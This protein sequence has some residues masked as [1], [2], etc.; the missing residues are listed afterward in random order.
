MQEPFNS[1]N[2]N[3]YGY[4]INNPLK[5][6][7]INGESFGQW[8]SRN[9]KSIGKQ[10]ENGWKIDKGFFQGD[11]G[12]ILSRFTW[13]SPQATLGYAFAHLSNAIGK[14]DNVQYYDGATVIKTKGN[15]V[16]FTSDVNGVTL[17]SFIVGNNKIEANTSNQLFMHEYGHYLQSQKYG[18]AYMSRFAFPSANDSKETEYDANSRALQYFYEKTGGNIR[19]DFYNFG[20]DSNKFRNI[21]NYNTP[22][23]QLALQNARLTPSA[24]DYGGQIFGGLFGSWLTNFKHKK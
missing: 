23:F 21:N 15:H 20:I 3:R 7:D 16:P 18:F 19:W 6:T 10:I 13:E 12:Q 9:V 14:V 1:Q 11:F 4:C 5:Y 17:S 8:V 22:D 2:Y 24:L